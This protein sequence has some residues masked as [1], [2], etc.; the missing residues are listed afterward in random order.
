MSS[1][2]AP[3]R[4]QHILPACPRALPRSQHELP[5]FQHA[6]RAL[7]RTLPRSLHVLAPS[8]HTRRRFQ[9]ALAASSFNVGSLYRKPVVVT[10]PQTGEKIKTKSKKWWGQ[11]KDAN[12]RLRRHPLAVDKMAAQ[13]M[14]NKL[15]KRVERQKAGLVDPTEEQ[16]KRPLSVHVAE[17]K[18][19]QENKNLTSKQVKETHSQ[20][21]KIIDGCK[22]QR[23]ADISTSSVMEYLGKLRRDGRSA[24]TCNHYLKAVKTFSRWLVGDRRTP[25][26][27][28]AHLSRFNVATDRRHDRR[29]LSPEEFTRLLD[30]AKT[31]KRIEGIRGPDRAMMYVL[32]AWTGFRKGEIGS[33]TL[34][35]LR[36]D[37]DPPTATVA[38][39]Y[40][41]RRREDRQ[42]LHVEVVRLLCE[43]LA[44]K[45]NRRPGDLL[46]PV[47]G[48]VPGGKERKTFKMVERDLAA[49]RKLWLDEAKND[50]KELGR[51]EQSDFLC[52][53]DHDGL[54]ADFHSLRHFF[55][56]SLSRSGASPKMAQAL[57]RHSDIR[58]T[59]QVYTH[60]ELA[61]QT[62]AIGALPGPGVTTAPARPRAASA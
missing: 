21:K 30:A 34:R 5:A 50:T 8:R 24:Q 31:G 7:R 9:Y 37:A 59:M 20:L 10:D 38:A 39:C 45:P 27:A 33:L 49:A 35:S 19:Y 26:N 53:R 52:H 16:R 36:L 46:F 12:G 29:A 15:V 23:I 48:R 62:A 28:L 25:Y 17:F 18:A 58:L 13:A 44:T 40:S 41:K 60:V 57:A 47:S 1:Q 4:S 51:R 32:A 54:Y 2:R 61:D 3:A 42:V 43:W 14:L 11:F 56:T 55:I 22:W 6:L